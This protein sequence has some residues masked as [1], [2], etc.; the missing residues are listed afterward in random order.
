[1]I[2]EKLFKLYSKNY[3]YEKLKNIL[4]NDNKIK[5][6]IDKNKNLSNEENIE[7]ISNERKN[8]LMNLINLKNY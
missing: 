1:M 6:S 4:N 8:I 5:L 2:N 7:K 3:D